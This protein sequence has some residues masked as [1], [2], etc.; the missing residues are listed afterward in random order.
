MKIH[1]LALQSLNMERG[2]YFSAR[3]AA[4][5]RSD[6]AAEVRFFEAAGRCLCLMTFCGTFAELSV[7][8]SSVS[9]F[10]SVFHGGSL[11]IDSVTT[12][13][14][15]GDFSALVMKFCK[16]TNKQRKQLM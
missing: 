2:R 12:G 13:D 1:L 5:A 16:C 11:F 3:S 8:V 10:F 14:N 6:A 7:L 15:D 9:V 4:A